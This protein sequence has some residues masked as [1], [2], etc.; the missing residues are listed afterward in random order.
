MQFLKTK[1]KMESFFKASKMYLKTT[2]DK[3]TPL[4]RWDHGKLI[5][6]KIK[7]SLLHFDQVQR[8]AYCRPE[9]IAMLINL[10]SSSQK[11]YFRYTG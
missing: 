9:F 3:E 8:A 1:I 2:I 11:R 4:I 7:Y 10:K 6:I 5:N